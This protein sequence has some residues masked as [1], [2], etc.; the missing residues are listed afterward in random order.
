MVDVSPCSLAHLVFV[1]VQAKHGVED[2][3]WDGYAMYDMDAGSGEEGR[4][5]CDEDG[6]VP[7]A[8]VRGVRGLLSRRIL[9]IKAPVPGSLHMHTHIHH[10]LPLRAA[11]MHRHLPRNRPLPVSQHRGRRPAAAGQSH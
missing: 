7:L 5:A 6:S 4:L 11:Q 9:A 3:E 2:E 8:C 1:L 10:H